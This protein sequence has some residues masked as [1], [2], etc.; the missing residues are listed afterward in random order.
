MRKGAIPLNFFI[1]LLEIADEASEEVIYTER[2]CDN[3]RCFKEKVSELEKLITKEKFDNEI[4]RLRAMGK[5]DALLNE[6][7]KLQNVANELKDKIR[8]L[9]GQM[10]ILRNENSKMKDVFFK[11]KADGDDKNVCF[12]VLLLKFGNSYR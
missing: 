12:I 7:H 2:C 3:C 10:D 9:E 8:C 4:E 1:E 5:I 11:T 6:K